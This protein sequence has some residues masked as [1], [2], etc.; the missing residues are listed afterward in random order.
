MAGPIP[1][2]YRVNIFR[3][4]YQRFRWDA[5]WSNTYWIELIS[6]GN[7]YLRDLYFSSSN[8]LFRTSWKYF[9]DHFKSF[10]SVKMLW[11]QFLLPR[12]R[13]LRV[14]RANPQKLLFPNFSLE[15][16]KDELS[17]F[18]FMGI[19]MSLLPMR[20][21]WVPHRIMLISKQDAH[22]DFV[23]ALCYSSTIF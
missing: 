22:G 13:M 11:D 18:L 5:L 7:L 12:C 8:L 6:L 4:V 20:V 1:N 3:L 9:T 17:L 19:K 21:S 16:T 14:K 2:Y 10:I 23:R 15:G